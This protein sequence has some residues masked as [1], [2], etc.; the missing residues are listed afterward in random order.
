M[1]SII[2]NIE[3]VQIPEVAAF[4]AKHAAKTDIAALALSANPFPE[5]PWSWILQQIQGK[6]KI[7]K[8]APLWANTQG[9]VLPPSLSIEQTSSEATA[10][11][12]AQL[13]L[14]GSLIDL[15]GGLGIDTYC[16]SRKATKVVHCEAQEALS[17]IA[18][19]NFKILKAENIECF[20][21][22]GFEYLRAQ[23][24]KWDTI[25]LDPARRNPN[26]QKIFLLSDCTPDIT[27]YQDILSACC[28]RLILKTSP[29]LDLSA[30]IAQL[31][32]VS[33]VHIVAVQ[34]EVKEL[35]WILDYET[36]ASNIEIV[37]ANIL[38]DAVQ[39][40]V[41]TYATQ[42]E[43]TYAL[44][45][46]YLY[47][48]NPAILKSGLFQAIGNSF[49]LQKLHAHTHLYTSKE[50]RTE[51]PGFVYEI[52]EVFP[53]NK[54]HYDKLAKVY[55]NTST[56]NFPATVAELL[57]KHKIKNGGDNFLFF[58]TDMEDIKIVIR[59]KKVKAN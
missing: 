58:C 25:Y 32:S 8:K 22:D 42:D 16:F 14:P 6:Q 44:P 7:A 19:H 50:L 33:A 29:L 21:G 30:T 10:R 35:I 59:C 20:A 51:F 28:K 56:R 2:K 46:K 57:K 5:I 12:K 36:K 49:G 41:H 45:Q 48:P 24:T 11:Y 9:I 13:A 37:C 52:E 39:T 38:E 1:C 17:T 27:Q 34:H 53:Y 55:A 15:T 31:P 26:Q 3:Q 23:N 4:I 43:A 54:Q 40:W 18:Q 47:L